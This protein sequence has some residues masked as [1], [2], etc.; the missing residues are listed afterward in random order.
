MLC[1]NTYFVVSSTTLFSGIL[2]IERFIYTVSYSHHLEC[3][4]VII[5]Q[6]LTLL[7]TS[8]PNQR[9]FGF[10]FSFNFRIH[11]VFFL[12][13]HSKTKYEIITVRRLLYELVHRFTKQAVLLNFVKLEL[14]ILFSRIGTRI[15]TWWPTKQNFG[16][17]I[18]PSVGSLALIMVS[19][20]DHTCL[21]YSRTHNVGSH[22]W[23]WSVKSA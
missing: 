19:G 21:F 20:Y 9:Y 16:P 10:R 23:S 2:H 14:I 15:Y 8:L 11:N 7:V 3:N 12:F 5:K 17:S 13:I 4:N 6:L 22:W 1:F 18:R